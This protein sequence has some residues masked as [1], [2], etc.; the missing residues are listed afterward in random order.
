MRVLLTGAAGYLGS[1]VQRALLAA[2]HEVIGVDLLLD[3]V[4]GPNPTV[5]EGVQRLDIR[6][7]DAL[8][9]LLDGV[10][11]VC[12]L[13]AAVP[14]PRLI[15]EPSRGGS[16]SPAPQELP[17]SNADPADGDAHLPESAR[18]E[19]APGRVGQRDDSGGH[20]TGPMNL[21]YFG[22]TTIAGHGTDN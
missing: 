21:A 19:H 8:E 18:H 15:A 13:A 5:P 17:R 16:N 11:V 10:D 20:G 9:P 3:A 2:G 6:D 12:H 14:V 7:P 4:H 1:H 22:T